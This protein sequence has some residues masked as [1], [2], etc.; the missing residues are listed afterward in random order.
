VPAESL[1][2][3]ERRIVADSEAFDR[4]YSRF[5]KDS[6]I[7]S[8][9]E[10]TGE[11]EVPTDLTAMLRLYET[12]YRLSKGKVNP[13]IGFALSDLGYDET[14]S[15]KK[16]DV[17]RPVPAL[18]EA[19]R[20]VDARR[21]ELKQSVLI[22]VGAVGKGYF[23][24]KIAAY[25][26]GQ[27]LKRFLV[28]GSGDIAYR[29]DGAPLRAGLEHPGDP[30]KAIGVVTMGS[31]AM[32]GSAGNRRRWGNYHHTIDP[33]TLTSP[34]EIVA[35]WVSAPSAAVADG[36]ATALFLCEP[37]DFAEEFDFECC[38]LNKEFRVRQS[39]GFGAELF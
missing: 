1:Q 23:V 21:I 10:R 33:L 16:K 32:C 19:L 26:A 29:T 11:V 2:A 30:T 6:I 9:V 35:T 17:V 3:I 18:P 22:D 4:A 28:N 24:D 14:Y 25:L 34:E 7:W 15:L 31:G 12:L 20:V 5:K 37:E 38:L 8:L 13:L 27:G 36:L 39:A